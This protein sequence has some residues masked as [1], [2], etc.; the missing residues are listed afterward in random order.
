M[1]K[2]QVRIV[3]DTNKGN[4]VSI[5]FDDGRGFNPATGNVA[6]ATLKDP[7]VVAEAAAVQ[8]ARPGGHGGGNCVI[9]NGRMVCP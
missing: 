6:L 4:V 2:D 1:A 5:E 7:I 9:V 3:F 8:C